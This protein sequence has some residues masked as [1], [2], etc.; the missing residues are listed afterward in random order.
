MINITTWDPFCLGEGK[1]FLVT[2]LP[3]S[4]ALSKSQFRMWLSDAKIWDIITLETKPHA[5]QGWD[6]LSTDSDYQWENYPSSLSSCFLMR[7]H[8]SHSQLTFSK[9]FAVNKF[10][11]GPLYKTGRSS[12]VMHRHAR[13]VKG[14]ATQVVRL[15]LFASRWSAVVSYNKCKPLFCLMRRLHFVVSVKAHFKL[16]RRQ[17]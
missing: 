9:K 3:T 16:A 1:L 14:L 4:L 15:C 6:S 12:V 10:V 2:P 11:W 13:S 7:W 5:M 17:N 8:L